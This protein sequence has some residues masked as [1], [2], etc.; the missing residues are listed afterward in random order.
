VRNTVK[1]AA[2]E[3]LRT[4]T[5]EITV[6]ARHKLAALR[7]AEVGAVSTDVLEGSAMDKRGNVAKKVKTI[8]E[9]T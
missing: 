7:M 2:R 8:G 3:K 6:E 9:N 4:V 1:V 5:M